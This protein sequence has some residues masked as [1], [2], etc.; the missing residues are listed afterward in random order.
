MSFIVEQKINGTTYV[1]RSEG[2]WDKQKKQARHRR[3]CIGKKD[4]ATGDIIP[5]KS[6]TPAQSCK[7]YGPFYLLNWIAQKIGLTDVV[8]KIFP[9]VWC[10]I[11]TLAFY[12]IAERSPLYLCGPWTLS[13]ETIDGVTLSSLRISELLHDIGMRDS[14]R[15]SVFRSWAAVRSE[16]ECIAYDITSISSYSQ[17]NEFLEFGCNRD[18]EDIPQIHLAMLF[19]ET[20]MMP[21]FYSILQGS[22]R[23]MSAISNM[24]NYAEKLDV[25][26]V[27]FVMDA[28]LYS[29]E[30][31]SEMSENKLKYTMGIPLTTAFAKEMV[32]TYREQLQSPSLTFAI[33]GEL[34]Q[35]IAVVKM[36]GGEK[37]RVFIYFN[38]RV[39]LGQKQALIKRILKLEYSF[40][41]MQSVP[42][43]STDACMKYLNIRRS[44]DGLSITRKNDE[45]EKM[46][47]YKGYMVMMSNDVR[48]AEECLSLYRSKNAF[49]TSFDNMNNE[50][51]IKQLLIHSDASM[52]GRIFIAFIGLILHSWIDKQMKE[53]KMYKRFTQEEV[54][55]ELK[56]LKIIELK[57]G[58]K[59]LT[60]LSKDQTHLFTEFGVPVPNIG[61]L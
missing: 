16:Q 33:N 5:S 11:L 18:E 13:T 50:E 48:S 36:I 44:K 60:E 25:K 42:P 28:G 43:K 20:S 58:T 24:L 55:S 47:R 26:N 41:D 21:I 17:V 49:E 15:M 7:D 32:D 52:Q 46:I 22:I 4:P 14:D 10:E 8:K 54:M 3:I 29:D 37:S 2:Y 31:L 45:I 30:N 35:G 53:K 9:D 12:E 57:K 27:R 39:Y 40:T 1:Y 51:D 38:E 56:R 61:L 19:G 34:I 23:D 6:V 59:I